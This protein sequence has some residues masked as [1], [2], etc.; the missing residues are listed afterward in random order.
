LIFP[1]ASLISGSILI[2]TTIPT[3]KGGRPVG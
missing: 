2:N 1:T 3:K